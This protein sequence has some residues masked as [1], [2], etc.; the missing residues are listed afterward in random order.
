MAHLADQKIYVRDAYAC[1]DENYKTTIRVI[2]AHAFQNI[3]ANNLFL[4]FDEG[5]SPA[6]PEWTIIAAPSFLADPTTD[7][8]RQELFYHQFLKK[9]IIIG[10]TAYT[11]E[12]K[13]G[14]FSVLNFILPAQRENISMHC[15]A[16]VGDEGDT[17]I[18]LGFRVREKLHCLQ[19]QKGTYWR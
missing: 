5:E 12:I 8:T 18:F 16:N 13:K 11:G 17:A 9:T 15:S 2:T 3:F 7:G 14:I 1:A 6:Q 10:G 19:T 4:R